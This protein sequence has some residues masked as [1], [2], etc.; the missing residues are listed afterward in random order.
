M[1]AQDY[2]S[3]I[4]S[5]KAELS[6]AQEGLEFANHEVQRI[7]NEQITWVEECNRIEAEIERLEEAKRMAAAETAL[8]EKLRQLRPL[9]DAI[10]QRSEELAEWIEQ[11]NDLLQEIRKPPYNCPVEGTLDPDSIPLIAHKIGIK[12]FTLGDRKDA[13]RGLG[14]WQE[15]PDLKPDAQP[16]GQ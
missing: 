3:Q 7:T 16:T 11:F 12:C 13:K 15:V 10:N 6:R 9:A 5:L 8:D 4:A 1:Q 2:S 14:L